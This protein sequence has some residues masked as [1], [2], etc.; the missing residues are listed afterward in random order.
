M[1]E[2][3]AGPPASAAGAGEAKQASG[4]GS[5]SSYSVGRYPEIVA[6]RMEPVRS[7]VKDEMV[8]YAYRCAGPRPRVRR[9][10]NCGD[11]PDRRVQFES[12]TSSV[13]LV[14]WTVS[15]WS[16]DSR[17]DVPCARRLDSRR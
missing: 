10:W 16:H 8:E 9:V 1:E 17:G 2:E 5:E 12:W 11:E 15:N 6:H 4:S 7:K 14:E 13:P 3:G